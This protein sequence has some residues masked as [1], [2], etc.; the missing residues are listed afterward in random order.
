MSILLL[1]AVTVFLF[2]TA[3]KML[4]ITVITKNLLSLVMAGEI[5]QVQNWSEPSSDNNNLKVGMSCVVALLLLSSVGC[6]SKTI[7][8]VP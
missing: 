3:L 6:S 8:K 2:H 7:L 1:Q 5:Q 4:Y